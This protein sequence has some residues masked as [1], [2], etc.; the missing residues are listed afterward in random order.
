MSLSPSRDFFNRTSN[1]LLLDHL[2][3]A[4]LTL[5]AGV[6]YIRRTLGVDIP[7]GGVHPAMG[8]HNHVMRLAEG[9]FLELIAPDP[10]A[11][12]RPRWFALDDKSMRA[13]LEASPRLITWVVRSDDIVKSLKSVPVMT[14]DAVRV[15]RESLSWL[16]SLLPDGRMPFDGAFPAII[17][18]PP[19]PHPSLGM[20]NLGC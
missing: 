18:W 4:A 10:A 17:Q 13:K 19:G 9:V 2:T 7:F 12:Q 14:G 5:E 1:M 20:A 6:A 16:F 11:T 8:T 15:T 3:V